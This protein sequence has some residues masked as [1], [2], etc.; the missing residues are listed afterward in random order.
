SHRAWTSYQ[1]LGVL[2]V[3]SGFS[4]ADE[5]MSGE[6]V[7]LLSRRHLPFRVIPK[8][9]MTVSSLAGLEAILY[10]DQDA[11][12]PEVRKEL[13]SSI[14]KGALMIVPSSWRMTEGQLSLERSQDGYQMYDI[15]TARIAV[16]KEEWRD[17]YQVASETHLIMS[18]STD[19]IRL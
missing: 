19:L 15:A 1:P 2:G 17:P 7:N 5:F 14:P 10:A 13:L 12:S 4:G 9:R 16:A 6:I 18:H 11:P 8:S 3:I